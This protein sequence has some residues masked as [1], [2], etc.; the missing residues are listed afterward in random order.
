VIVIVA[1]AAF[2]ILDVLNNDAQYLKE[3]IQTLRQLFRM[4]GV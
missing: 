3:G 1:F 2:L 4:I